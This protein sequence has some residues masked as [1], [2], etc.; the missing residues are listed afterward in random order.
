MIVPT[1]HLNGTSADRLIEDLCTASNALNDA[2]GWIQQT[3]PN[4]RDWYPQGPAAFEQA[5]A[6]HFAR[7]QRIDDVKA[8]I[9]AL[10]LAIHDA[11]HPL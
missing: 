3:A 11:A 7:L 1:I 10:T 5:Q 8:E 9:D 6:E 2:Y 4:G